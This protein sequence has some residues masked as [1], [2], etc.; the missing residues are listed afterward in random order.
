[1]KPYLGALKEIKVGRPC[2]IESD[3]KGH[4]RGV[5]F[6]DDGET[7]YFYAS[8]RAFGVR[9]QLLTRCG[10]LGEMRDGTKHSN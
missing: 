10:D 8:E 9:V 2:V 7:G 4:P 6:E 5:V 1:M 3:A